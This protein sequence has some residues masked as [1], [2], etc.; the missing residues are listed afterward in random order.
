[1]QD[2]PILTPD[3]RVALLA[4]AAILRD[5]NTGFARKRPK[6]KL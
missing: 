4:M 2:E 3:E 5:R 6:R 1:M